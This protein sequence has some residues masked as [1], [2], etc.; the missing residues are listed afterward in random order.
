MMRRTPRDV[1]S[2]DSVLSPGRVVRV[3]IALGS[4][5]GDRRSHI[6]F[7]IK[8]LHSLLTEVVGSGV[9]ESEAVGGVRQPCFLNAVVVGLTGME[10]GGLLRELMLIEYE[11]GRE[12]PFAGAPR[13]LDLDLILFGDRIVDEAD[14]QV[15][16]PRFRERH[17]VIGPLA[18][19]AP[20][21][22]DPLS[23]LTAHQLR[24]ELKATQRYCG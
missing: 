24:V 13:T 19:I 12:R 8:R 21:M 10:P 4:N 15:P 7:A 14:L 17:F 11:R 16:H 20:N 23:G 22:R 6:D 5:I 1:I 3:A 18:E 9:I 2:S